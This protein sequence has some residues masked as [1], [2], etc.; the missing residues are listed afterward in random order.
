MGFRRLSGHIAI[1][2]SARGSLRLWEQEFNEDGS[3]GC[4]GSLALKKTVQE[5]RDE[6]KVNTRKNIDMLGV[7]KPC[8]RLRQELFRCSACVEGECQSQST[9]VRATV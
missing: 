4:N 3:V 7:G 5:T 8:W 1:L 6:W 2:S 9:M